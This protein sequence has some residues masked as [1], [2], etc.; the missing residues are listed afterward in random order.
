MSD[1][2]AISKEPFGRSGSV[3]SGRQVA[4]ASVDILLLLVARGRAV[5]PS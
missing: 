2:L 3:P 4:G 5:R 1:R